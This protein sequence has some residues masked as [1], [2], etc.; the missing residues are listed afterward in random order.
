MPKRLKQNGFTLIE[1]LVVIAIGA[2]LASIAYASYQGSITK[3]R[4]NSAVVAIMDV[5]KRQEE[6]FVNNKAYAT[7]LTSLGYTTNPYYVDKNGSGTSSGDSIYRI[8]LATGAST[9]AFT[10]EAVPQNEQTSDSQCGTLQMSSTG[11]KSISG[12]TESADACF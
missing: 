3:S 10:V 11:A 5:L 12:G 6:Y 9:S 8:Q 7:A 4:R 2:T 1:T